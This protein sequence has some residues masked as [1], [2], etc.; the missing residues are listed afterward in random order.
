MEPEVQAPSMQLATRSD[1]AP[2][3]GEAEITAL[4]PA[5][6]LES[7]STGNRTTDDRSSTLPNIQPG[8]VPRVREAQTGVRTRCIVN[9]IPSGQIAVEN[10]TSY[11]TCLSAGTKCAGSRPYANIQFFVEPGSTST[12]SPE[13]CNAAP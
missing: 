3:D 9:L 6:H 1:S 2:N 7:P 5:P 12:N 4:E 13:L 8:E 10:G 11:Q